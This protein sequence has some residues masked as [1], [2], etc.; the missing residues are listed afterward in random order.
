MKCEAAQGIKGVFFFFSLL[1]RVS[2][3]SGCVSTD[4]S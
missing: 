2:S 1:K 3:F 4:D